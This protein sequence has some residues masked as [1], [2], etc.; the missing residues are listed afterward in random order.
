[1][2]ASTM[3]HDIGF[4]YRLYCL[5]LCCYPARF[6]RVYAQEMART[7]RDSYREAMQQRGRSGVLRLWGVIFYDLVISLFSE[8][9]SAFKELLY[10]DEE[11]HGEYSMSNT[12]IVFAQRSDIGLKRES[13]EDSALS[14]QPEDRKSVV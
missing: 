8:Y 11:R 9:G 3:K 14:F 13:N 6:R 2:S 12:N 10:P 7:F 4:S 5:F 1:M